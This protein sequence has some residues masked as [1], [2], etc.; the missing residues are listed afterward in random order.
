[1]KSTLSL[2]VILSIW[3]TLFAPFSS[4]QNSTVSV[5]DQKLPEEKK[6]LTVSCPLFYL[7]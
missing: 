3:T 7:G 4:A 5:S 2:L 6:G 1:M